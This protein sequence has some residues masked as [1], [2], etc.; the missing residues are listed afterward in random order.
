[1]DC[2]AQVGPWREAVNRA[3]QGGDAPPPGE[4]CPGSPPAAP[5]GSAHPAPGLSNQPVTHMA[6]VCLSVQETLAEHHLCARLCARLHTGNHS[7]KRGCE[8]GRLRAQ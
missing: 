8:Q 5:Q 1:M 4:N 7:Q 6:T 3:P 2:L